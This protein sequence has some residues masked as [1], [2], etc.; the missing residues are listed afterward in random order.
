MLEVFVI[1]RGR[2]NGERFVDKLAKLTGIRKL[3]IPLEGEGL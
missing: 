1:E 2:L 3:L